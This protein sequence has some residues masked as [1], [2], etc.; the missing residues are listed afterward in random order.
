M[1]VN[2][3]PIVKDSFIVTH[4]KTLR[5][6]FLTL[7][8]NPVRTVVTVVLIAVSLA[9][10]M[11][12][13][14][15]YNNAYIIT[16][17]LNDNSQ[18]SLYLKEGVLK[19]EI[20]VLISKIKKNPNIKSVNFISKEQG[21][22][23]FSKIS[24]FVEPLE[25]LDKNPLPDV[26]EIVPSEDI[27]NTKAVAEE[28]LHEFVSYPEVEQ[29]KFDFMWIQKL[30]AIAKLI[31]N[32]AL[33]VGILLS[34]GVILTVANT[35]RINLLAHKDEIEIMKIFGATDSFVSRP[36]LYIGF[37]LGLIGG[38]LAWWLNTFFIICITSIID[39]IATLYGGSYTLT[40]LTFSES[41]VSVII[42]IT[43][44][45]IATKLSLNRILHETC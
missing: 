10:P 34:L 7:G 23:E 2:K 31:R 15:F 17:S 39:N 37:W 36:Y 3:N 45:I 1:S 26:I 32:L 16:N 41:L 9:V 27:S 19:D 38:F 24:G 20:D 44:S 29:G 21:L 33:S 4:W 8:R 13:Y 42:S 18:I 11:T 28:M 40:Q 35:I 12:F 14:V 43:L 22:E 25:L 6:S 5:D 30:E